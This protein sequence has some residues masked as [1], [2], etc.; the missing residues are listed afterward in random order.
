MDVNGIVSNVLS[1]LTAEHAGRQVDLDVPPLPSVVADASLLTQVFA[2]L[3]S[4]AFKFTR[5]RERAT[6]QVGS[7]REDTSNLFF[8][9]DNGAGFD[10]RYASK[11]FGMFQRLQTVR[12]VH[13]DRR[14]AVAR[15]TYREAAWRGDLGR[16]SG[17]PRCDVQVLDSGLSEL[18]PVH[19]LKAGIRVFG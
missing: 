18:F 17:R 10:M 16:G 11:L 13:G 6:I 5:H 14:R 8:V 9:R 15:P 3:L 4:N 12:R 2:N 19:I 7:V 1:E